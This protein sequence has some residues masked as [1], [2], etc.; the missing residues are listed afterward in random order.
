MWLFLRGD[1]LGF[2]AAS[3]LWCDRVRAVAR[4]A[5]LAFLTRRCPRRLGSAN[6]FFLSRKY[7]GKI[8]GLS[9][10]ST[11][12]CIG[13]R[14]SGRVVNNLK[15][16]DLEAFPTSLETRDH[17]KEM[18]SARESSNLFCV[19]FFSS[20]FVAR[21]RPLAAP[22]VLRAHARRRHAPREASARTTLP[23]VCRRYNMCP[24]RGCL[25]LLVRNL[26]L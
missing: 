25:S 10:F 1:A 12:V 16:Y 18:C 5:F 24:L 7:I 17:A 9:L 3:R 6:G 22:A 4:A 8:L 11:D 2:A 13:S 19:D 15:T 26:S 21:S 14:R 20:F 23:Y